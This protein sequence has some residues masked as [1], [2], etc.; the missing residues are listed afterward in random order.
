[1]NGGEANAAPEAPLG[2]KTDTSKIWRV[3]F[4]LPAQRLD[5]PVKPLCSKDSLRCAEFLLLSFTFGKTNSRGK[6]TK[7]A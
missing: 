4:K 1:M 2:I 7:H 6:P 5:W 3:I